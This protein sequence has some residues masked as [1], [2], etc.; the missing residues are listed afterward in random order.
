MPLRWRSGPDRI[1]A[2]AWGEIE[3]VDLLGAIQSLSRLED[4]PE[5]LIDATHVAGI[6]TE[7]DMVREVVATCEAGR[8]LRPDVPIAVVA[9]RDVVYGAARQLQLSTGTL[10]RMGVFRRREEATSW[11]TACAADETGGRGRSMPGDLP[12]AWS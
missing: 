2:R 7:P 1:E 12:G 6:H 11:L 3:L 9:G 5:L 4:P 8:C 10:L